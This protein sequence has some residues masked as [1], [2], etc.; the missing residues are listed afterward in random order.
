MAE[1]AAK[2]TVHGM[3]TPPEH[4]A[5]PPS[6]PSTPRATAEPAFGCTVEELRVW[7]IQKVKNV[8]RDVAELENGAADKHSSPSAYIDTAVPGAI[9]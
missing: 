2:L 5:L 3:E 7:M 4:L 6:P 9:R 8:D 1:D